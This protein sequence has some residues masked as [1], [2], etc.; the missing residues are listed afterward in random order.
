MEGSGL[1]ENTEQA[2]NYE[3]LKSLCELPGIAGREDAVRAF[4]QE[5]MR[6]LV[7][8]ISVDRMG[9]VIGV[10]NGSGGPTVMVSAHM[11]E[12]GF[13]VKHIDDKGFLRLQPVG[14]FDPRVLPAQRVMVHGHKGDTLRGV[15]ALQSKPIHLLDPSDMKAP[16]V[17][18]IFVDVGL[19]GDEVKEL[20]DIGDMVVLDR[21]VERAGN[22]VIGKALDDRL[23]VFVMLEAL[24][25]LQGTQTNAT[26]VAV[27]SVQ[28]EVGLRGARTSAFNADPDIGVA[29]DVTLAMDIPGAAEQDAVSR[30]GDGVAIKIMDS[31]HISNHKLVQHVRQLARDNDV[32]HQ[33]EIL[34]RGGTD[35]GAM[36]LARGGAP[37]ITL[38][39]PTRYIHTVNEMCAVTDIEATIRLLAIYLEN[40]HDGD[41]TF[42]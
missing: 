30:L 31:S 37:V 39:L 20:V 21:T 13:L 10:K 19:P 8:E 27:A 40:A 25:A 28:E 14:G 23:S 1:S 17:D 26:I 33:M 15:L 32:P 41:Y 4:V 5:Q 36:Q 42:G 7:D 35:A 29:L 34:P 11:D 16:K 6:D 24:K 38:S 9:N 22:T 18:D 12:I 3:L 2:F